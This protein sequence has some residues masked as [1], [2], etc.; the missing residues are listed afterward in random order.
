MLFLE[1]LG[2]SV[3]V[4]ARARA[5]GLLRCWRFGRGLRWPQGFVL[6]DVLH[7]LAG[8]IAI[9]RAQA[10]H[11]SGGGVDGLDLSGAQILHT[12][13]YADGLDSRASR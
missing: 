12:A 2:G 6:Q 7:L 10:N 9:H 3:L 4:A 8:L 1:T 11:V 5:T 13:A